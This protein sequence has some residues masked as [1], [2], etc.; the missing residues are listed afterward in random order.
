MFAVV[1]FKVGIVAV[2]TDKFVMDALEAFTQLELVETL[3][4]DRHEIDDAFT[5]CD[6]YRLLQ[7]RPG[8]KISIATDKLPDE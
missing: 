4:I 8:E 2:V 1:E 6:T 7:F 5:C 3:V